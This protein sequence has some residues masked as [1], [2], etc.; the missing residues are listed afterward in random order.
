MKAWQREHEYM[1]SQRP[2]RDPDE[3]NEA[4]WQARHGGAGDGAGCGRSS[5]VGLHRA[6][7]LCKGAGHRGGGAGHGKQGLVVP[8]SERLLSGAL[9]ALQPAT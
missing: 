6:G 8:G 3:N 2:K 7:L 9:L 1:M 5:G 4:V